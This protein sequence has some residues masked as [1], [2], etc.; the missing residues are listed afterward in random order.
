MATHQSA[1]AT[2]STTSSPQPRL[3]VSGLRERVVSTAWPYSSHRF[4]TRMVLSSEAAWPARGAVPSLLRRA[5]FTLTHSQRLQAAAFRPLALVLV[6]ALWVMPHKATAQLLSAAAISSTPQAAQCER[7]AAR[8]EQA[9]RIPAGLLGAIARVESGR[10]AGGGILEPWPWTVNAQGQ[11]LFFASKVAAVA[12][13]GQAEAAGITSIDTGCLQVNLHYH[14][15]A[16]RSLDEAFDIAANADYAGRFLRRLVEG[17]ARG[18]WLVAA[19]LYHSSTPDR[20][21][22]YRAKVA[23]VLRGPSSVRAVGAAAWRLAATATCPRDAGTSAVAAGHST[24]IRDNP[25]LRPQ[26]RSHAFAS[27]VLHPQLAAT[28]IC[29]GPA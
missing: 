23:A 12:W 1:A 24:A 21:A 6:V 27:L 13:V 11:G 14:P 15:D 16:F 10:A 4:F 8:S 2:R 3:G 29:G 9:H 20:A 28:A 18:D 25:S 5:N 19:G 7:A 22:E 26:P 17:P